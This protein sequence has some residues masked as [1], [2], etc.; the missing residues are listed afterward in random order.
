MWK[1]VE[2]SI[3]AEG[4]SATRPPD[5]LECALGCDTQVLVYARH[6]SVPSTP[7]LDESH[8]DVLSVSTVRGRTVGVLVAKLIR[9]QF[10]DPDWRLRIEYDSGAV[11]SGTLL[12]AHICQV[13][14][15]TC[16]KQGDSAVLPSAGV[17]FAVSGDGSYLVASIEGSPLGKIPLVE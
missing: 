10:L 14:C 6:S 3:Y 1:Q 17:S 15:H 12:S 11:L 9:A 13:A 16:E 4:A 7:I 2:W 5:G 8:P